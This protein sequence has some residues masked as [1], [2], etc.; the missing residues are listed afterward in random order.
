MKALRAFFEMTALSLL[1]LL[2]LLLSLAGPRR[3]AARAG[4]QATQPTAAPV[5]AAA[6]AAAPPA[7]EPAPA[8]ETPVPSSGDASFQVDVLFGTA[9]RSLSLREYLVG[10]VAAEMP[11]SFET[12]ALEAQAVAA[13]TDTLYR[14]TVSHPHR[15]AACCTDPGCCKAW[16]SPEDLRARWGD[17]Y[18]RWLAKIAAAVDAT[19]GEILLYGD[20]PIFAAFHAASSGRTEDSENVWTA[21][22]PYLRGVATEETAERVPGFCRSTVFTEAELAARVREGVPGAELTGDPGGWLADARRSASGRLLSVSVGGVTLSGTA[23]RSLLGLRSAA[24]TWTR[25]EG[26]F[27]FDTEGF[28]HGV[29]MSQYGAEVMAEEGSGCAEILLHYYTGVR[30]GDMS[31][32]F[33]A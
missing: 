32:V 3:A 28:G 33:P 29:G 23:F 18:G 9:V 2:V 6:P 30:L 25:E 1:P 24:V 10:V 26:A 7:A 22:L 13:R 17:D 19:D 14:L 15:E 4:G 20:E 31:E 8:A 21:A 12:A 5:P 27:R 16:A 11:A